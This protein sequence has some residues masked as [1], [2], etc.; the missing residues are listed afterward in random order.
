MKNKHFTLPAV[1]VVET[2]SHTENLQNP[3]T[4]L[5]VLYQ[6]ITKIHCFKNVY[7]GV[8]PSFGHLKGGIIS[9][10]RLESRC[11]TSPSHVFYWR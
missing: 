4:L 9:S 8:A 11:D 2:R 6:G 7:V 5:H 10:K 1:F 3:S